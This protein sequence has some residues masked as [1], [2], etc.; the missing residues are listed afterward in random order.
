[1][2]RVKA[3][4]PRIR[5]RPGAIFAGLHRPL[6]LRPA[7][8]A[9]VI[10]ASIGGVP[11]AEASGVI[12]NVPAQDVLGY[13]ATM[14]GELLDLSGGATGAAAFDA[15]LE[16]TLY[17][18]DSAAISLTQMDF[19]FSLW[20]YLSTRKACSL[21]DKQQ[22]GS[23]SHKEYWIGC[24]GTLPDRWS[25]AVHKFYGGWSDVSAYTASPLETGRWRHLVF[26][27]GTDAL[28]RIWIDAGSESHAAPSS[29]GFVD[30]TNPL[31]LGGTPGWDRYLDG[32]IAMVGFWKR[33]LSAE[34][35]S[36]LYNG[37]NG[38]TYSE[39]SA[40]LKDATL[41]AYWDV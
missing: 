32:R 17:A 3:A 12:A 5:S 8:I 19:T 1:M 36:F 10:L 7:C 21:L 29:G 34:E 39:L 30:G 33:E 27:R 25:A 4:Q 28:K 18:A 37:G 15:A 11:P 16:Q 26:S 31:R 14:V 20:A 38:R 35:R 9:A 13:S 2:G 6:S 23:P 24:D 40:G 22:P 41:M